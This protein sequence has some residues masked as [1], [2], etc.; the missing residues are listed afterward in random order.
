MIQ[1]LNYLMIQLY[2]ELKTASF[3]ARDERRNL[4]QIDNDGNKILNNELNLKNDKQKIKND[5]IV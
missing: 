5:T 1:W 4:L 2:N 3:R